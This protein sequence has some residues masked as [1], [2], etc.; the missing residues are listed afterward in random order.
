M[1]VSHVRSGGVKKET[2]GE[3][4]TTENKR[5]TEKITEQKGKEKKKRER[6]RRKSLLP[7]FFPPLD[8]WGR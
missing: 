8:R 3:K 4:G 2:G 1:R 7:F 5:N 6:E